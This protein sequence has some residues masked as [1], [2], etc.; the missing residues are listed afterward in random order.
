MPTS[1]SWRKF[2]ISISSPAPGFDVFAVGL[3]ICRVPAGPK[4]HPGTSRS[5]NSLETVNRVPE[6]CFAGETLPDV[7]YCSTVQHGLQERPS[8]KHHSKR[9]QAKNLE[10]PK[11]RREEGAIIVRV[12]SITIGHHILGHYQSPTRR[13]RQHNAGTSMLR[14][15]TCVENPR[16]DRLQGGDG[17]DAC[18]SRFGA[19]ERSV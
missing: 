3:S 14:V 8:S 13:L 7:H 4:S 19:R 9:S 1:T 6:G 2:V 18:F 10:K 15:P 5:R 12:S 17:G 16:A 11:G